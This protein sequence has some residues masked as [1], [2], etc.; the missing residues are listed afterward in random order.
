MAEEAQIVVGP[1]L[2]TA[3]SDE[4]VAFVEKRLEEFNEARNPVL[5]RMHRLPDG[6]DEP[7]QVY[8]VADGEVVGGVVGV[9]W[10]EWLHI[11]LLWVHEAQRGNGLGARLMA[12]AER[13]ARERGCGHARTETWDFQAPRFYRAQGYRVVG[14]V[15]DYP[16]G[17]IEYLLIKDL[18]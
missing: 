8:A 10:A 1:V 4:R 13:I 5:R 9:I 16:P 12:A 7:V 2:E 14:E 15:R 17:A 3:V 18:A 6:G 11:D